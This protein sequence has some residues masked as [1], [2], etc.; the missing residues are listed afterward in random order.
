MQIALLEDLYNVLPAMTV[1]HWF[2]FVSFLFA[3]PCLV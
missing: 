2:F 3:R 1:R